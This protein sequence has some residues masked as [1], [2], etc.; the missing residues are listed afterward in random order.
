MGVSFNM[1]DMWRAGPGSASPQGGD[2]TGPGGFA[3]DLQV[4]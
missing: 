2:V 1:P 4:I 3:T